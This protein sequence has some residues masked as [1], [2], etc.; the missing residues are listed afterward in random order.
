[1]RAAYFIFQFINEKKDFFIPLVGEACRENQQV[2]FYPANIIISNHSVNSMQI[3][4]CESRG[5]RGRTESNEAIL[6]VALV[7]MKVG[8]TDRQLL[9]HS[10]T[11]VVKSHLVVVVEC[12]R[13]LVVGYPSH[14]QRVSRRRLRT[15]W[16]QY[17]TVVTEALKKRS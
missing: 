1:M 9:R 14:G 8:R 15:T 3:F 5:R 16:L 12:V 7:E 6:F 4:S 2:L 11:H 17:S 13:W 10:L